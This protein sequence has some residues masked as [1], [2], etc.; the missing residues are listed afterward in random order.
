LAMA[1]PNQ[2]RGFVSHIGFG[3][4]PFGSRIAADP[5]VIR[6]AIIMKAMIEPLIL[7]R[8][9]FGSASGIG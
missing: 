1:Y 4:K 5:V 8:L 7:R 9:R 6:A 2:M 3:F